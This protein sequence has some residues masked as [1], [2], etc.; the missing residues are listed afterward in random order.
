MKKRNYKQT[1]LPKQ[2][3]PASP[4]TASPRDGLIPKEQIQKRAYAIFETRGGAP[5]HELEDWLLAEVELKAEMAFAPNGE[6]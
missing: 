6:A 1:P 4:N 5:G 3:S 2:E